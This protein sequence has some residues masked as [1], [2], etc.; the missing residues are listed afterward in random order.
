M[1]SGGW[2]TGCKVAKRGNGCGPRP[3]LA[4]HYNQ[5]MTEAITFDAHRFVKRLMECDFTEKKA[6]TLADEQV[7]MP[8]TNLAWSL[9]CSNS[10]SDAWSRTG[11]WTST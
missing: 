4:R 8:N 1:A 3:L 10:C 2:S 5:R 7:S 11:V 6:E 9:P